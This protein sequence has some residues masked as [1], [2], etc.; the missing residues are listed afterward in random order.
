M[1]DYYLENLWRWKCGLPELSGIHISSLDEEQLPDIDLLKK[2]QWSDK[3]QEFV[4]RSIDDYGAYKKW[5]DELL[6]YSKNR[7]VMG[8]FRYGIIGTQASQSFNHLSSIPKRYK[9][10]YID[11]NIEWLADIYN[12]LMLQWID[13]GESDSTLFVYARAVIR[14]FVKHYNELKYHSQDDGSIHSEKA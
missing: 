12:L 2:T 7:M 4:L 5:I 11:H 13:T 10:F 9:Q 1:I 14:I 3:F 6:Y 8:A